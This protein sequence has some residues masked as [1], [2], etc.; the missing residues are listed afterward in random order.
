MTN[1]S[2]NSDRI[3]KRGESS[4]TGARVASQFCISNVE[5]ID[6]LQNSLTEP[7]LDYQA[8]LTTCEQNAD[9]VLPVLDAF[10][11]NAADR[12][13]QIAEY[14]RKGECEQIV[15]AAHE[16]KA[17]AD[18]LSANILRELAELLEQAGRCGRKTDQQELV[19]HLRRETDRCLKQLPLVTATARMGAWS[20]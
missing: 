6:L 13:T 11:A 10:Q 7:P 14:V 19:E 3:S 4:D 2:P 16:F 1:I 17:Q 18:L 9:F 20:N 8:L 15:Q 5:L 12:V